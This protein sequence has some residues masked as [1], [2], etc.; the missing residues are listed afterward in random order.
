MDLHAVVH[1]ALL[2]EGVDCWRPVSARRIR[3]NVFV[4]E[5]SVPDDERWEFVPGQA[6]VCE[7]HQFSDGSQGIVAVR[8]AL[9]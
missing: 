5:G 8:I 1:V 4:L 7:P 2:D 6:V 9:S 3:E